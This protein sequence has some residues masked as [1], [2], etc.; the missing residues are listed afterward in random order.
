MP[1]KTTQQDLSVNLVNFLAEMRADPRFQELV[2]KLPQFR[3]KPYSPRGGADQDRQFYYQ[4]GQ[5]DA[6]GKIVSF[7]VGHDRTAEKDRR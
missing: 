1:E 4:S 6:A 3:L 7:L 2:D 5:V